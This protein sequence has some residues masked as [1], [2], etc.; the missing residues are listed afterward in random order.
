MVILS[1][2]SGLS[3][4]DVSGKNVAKYKALVDYAHGKGIQL[5]GYSLFSSR[6]INDETDVI[7]FKTGKPGGKLVIATCAANSS[8]QTKYL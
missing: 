8:G 1:F 3:M 4:E 2:G 7:D 5:G 6:R